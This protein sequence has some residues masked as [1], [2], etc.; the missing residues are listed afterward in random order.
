MRLESGSTRYRV[1]KGW[2]AWPRPPVDLVSHMAVVCD[3]ASTRTDI[4]QRLARQQVQR[5]GGLI[6][7]DGWASAATELL[8]ENLA[9]KSMPGASFWSV[10]AWRDARGSDVV[11]ACDPLVLRKRLLERGVIYVGPDVIRSFHDTRN[12]VEQI[13]EGVLQGMALRRHS[14]QLLKPY[15]V[16]LDHCTPWLAASMSKR[17]QDLL[18]QARESGVVLVGLF[19]GED[20]AAEMNGH[21]PGLALQAGVLTVGR[22]RQFN[23]EAVFQ[24]P[25][26]AQGGLQAQQ[27]ARMRGPAS[28]LV[29]SAI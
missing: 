18:E 25:L 7:L 1:H 11:L 3:D 12:F 23:W 20:L 27:L 29:V 26:A 8:L 28:S 14:A 9:R 5:E 16:V 6:W 21:G 17:A 10:A 4:A 2:R 15:M 13:L 22:L 24:H 19:T